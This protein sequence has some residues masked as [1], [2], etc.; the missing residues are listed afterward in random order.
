ME[1]GSRREARVHADFYLRGREAS[2]IST[3][4]TEFKKLVRFCEEFRKP[5]CCLK[6][7]D[8]VSFIIWRARDGVSEGQL[9]QGLAVVSLLSEICGFESPAKSQVVNKV[10]LAVVKEANEGKRKVER[11]GMTKEILEVIVKS[12]YNK[13]S[14]L[15]L[16]ERRRFMMMKIMCF[17]GV[18]RFN[19]IHKIKRK[20]VTVRE[21]GRVKVW[22]EKTK[23]DKKREGSEF[24]LTK[25]KIGKLSVT[26]L[27][28]WYLESMGDIPGD[29]YIFPVF[30]RGVP[31]WGQAVSYNTAR[32]QLNKIKEELGLGDITWHSGRIGAASEAHKKRV[33]RNV[34]MKSGGWVSSA[35]DTYM[36]VEDPGVLVG[37]ALL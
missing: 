15:V 26:S 23:T 8:V 7:R 34:I 13:D 12:C 18:K 31:V 11:I 25:S 2:T 19:D 21:D 37:D 33:S 16:P 1:G 4:N 9:R 5:I 24:V 20:N 30:K 10:K 22:I 27:V 28:K 3:Y 17:L 14:K 6:E 36:R 29:A 35:V 32:I